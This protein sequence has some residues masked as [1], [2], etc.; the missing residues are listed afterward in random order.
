VLQRARSWRAASR[1]RVVRLR[2]RGRR[3]RNWWTVF[4]CSIA[5]FR[6]MHGGYQC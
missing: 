2:R 5:G 6:P 4:S 1:Q 3:R